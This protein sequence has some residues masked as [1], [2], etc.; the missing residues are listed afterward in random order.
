MEIHAYGRQGD[1]TAVQR[2]LASG[3][4]I[5][6]V[7]EWSK[8]PLMYAVNDANINLDMV[9]FL[10]ENGADVNAIEAIFKNNVL[11]LA[12]QSGNLEKIQYLLDCDADINYQS[13]GGYDV[14]IN[15]MFGRDISRCENLISIVNLLITRGAKVN[16]HV[17]KFKPSLYK[18]FKDYLYVFAQRSN[19]GL[20]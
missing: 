19:K 16:R 18:G 20:K 7:D 2:Q 15:S 11:G 5:D 1:I 9:R 10:I 6:C 3:V 8:T 4:D 17:R 14:L 13:P 12:V